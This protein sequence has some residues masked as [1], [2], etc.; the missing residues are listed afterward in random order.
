[1]SLPSFLKKSSRRGEND[2][3]SVTNGAQTTSLFSIDL[4]LHVVVMWFL[5]W[6]KQTCSWLHSDCGTFIVLALGIISVAYA[7]FRELHASFFVSSLPGNL[8]RLFGDMERGGKTDSRLIIVG[9]QTSE[10]SQKWIAAGLRSSHLFKGL[11]EGFPTLF[12]LASAVQEA[13]WL[14]RTESPDIYLS[15]SL[16]LSGFS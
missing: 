13:R 14:L 8:F 6:I 12:S 16:Q 5:L 15:H 3:S 9:L 2:L 11:G 4:D 7:C 1:M 10:T